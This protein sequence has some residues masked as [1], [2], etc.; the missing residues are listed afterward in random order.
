MIILTGPAGSGKDTIANILIKEHN[1]ERIL[2]VTTREKRPTE[3]DG[4]EYFFVDEVAYESLKASDQLVYSRECYRMQNG[5]N[6]F[7]KYGILKQSIV[8]APVRSI[9]STNPLAAN[10]IATKEL[11][12]HHNVF[13]VELMISPEIQ[14]ERLAKRGDESKE[15][16][17]RIECDQQ[18]HS[19]PS[20]A[21]MIIHTD[22]CSIDEA[23]DKVLKAYK[24][25]KGD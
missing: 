10:T 23:V 16:E 14:R 5:V 9:L 1:F 20:W 17:Q 4:R 8:E 11:K 6:T 12:E 25:L 2:E 13:F 24:M 21:N 19:N 18:Y 3:Q 7:V 15:I 22:Q